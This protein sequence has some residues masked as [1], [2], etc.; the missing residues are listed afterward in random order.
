MA[1]KRI[2]VEGMNLEYEGLFRFN[3]LYLVMEQWLKE[4]GYDK[5]D[6]KN[7]EQVLKTGRDIRLD[8]WPWK[9]ITDYAKIQLKII[10]HVKEMKDVVVKKDERD[11]KMNQGK[12][13][14]NFNGFLIT[15]IKDKWEGKPVFYFL[16]MVFD[17]WV[18]RTNTDKLAGAVGDEVDQLYNLAKSHLNMYRY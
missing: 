18:Y 4:K 14:I 17:R 3:D 2:V 7:Y 11:V 16:R 12:V 13:S 5:D 10:I 8:L 6:R 1:E 15:D 9:T